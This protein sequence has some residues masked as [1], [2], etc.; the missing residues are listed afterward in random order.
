MYFKTLSEEEKEACVAQLRS[1]LHHAEGLIKQLADGLAS[2][3]EDLQA[4]TA[5][6]TAHFVEM[7]RDF[8]NKM[9]KTE[10]AND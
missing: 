4:K 8:F 9:V 10:E 3:D 2:T 7:Y 1:N 5:T 6:V